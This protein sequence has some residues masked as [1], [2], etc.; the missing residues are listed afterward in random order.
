MSAHPLL[1]LGLRA[2]WAQAE[3][4]P[5]SPAPPAGAVVDPAPAPDRSRLPVVPP[6]RLRPPLEPVVMTLQNDVQAWIL[7][8][9]GLHRARVS[10]RF[11]D[12]ISG[13]CPRAPA[14]CAALGDQLGAGAG[15]LDAEAVAQ[16]LDGIDA[17]LRT[18]MG[19]DAGWVELDAPLQHLD[20]GLDRL[21]DVLIDPSLSR[22]ELRR[23]R[24]ETHQ[25]L[26]SHWPSDP[27]ATLSEAERHLWLPP[28]HPW[29]HRASPGAVRRVRAGDLR[30]AQA[31]RAARSPLTVFVVGDVDPETLRPH[32]ALL[33]NELGPGAAGP[34]PG[35]PPPAHAGQR[36]IGVDMPGRSQAALGLSLAAPDSASPEAAAALLLSRVVMD[37]FQSRINLLLREERGWTYGVAGRWEAAPGAARFQVQVELPLDKVVPAVVDI[38]SEL[39]RAAATPPSQAE[40]AREQAGVAREHNRALI[41][42]DSASAALVSAWR[43]GGAAALRAR[44]DAVMAV[45]PADVQALA[46]RALGPEAARR[47]VVVGDRAAL[48]PALA[49]AGFDVRWIS[50]QDAVLGRFPTD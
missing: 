20:L 41:D 10:V 32:L 6:P 42:E 35:P 8:T 26:T 25:A 2:A 30:A 23:W 22:R 40:L 45:Q 38:E 39:A 15:A 34:Q 29:G 3:A 31:E 12:G 43:W 46:A 47:W 7:P 19:R 24:R 11:A 44:A 18:A 28:D 17:E 36:W 4:E 50:P 37:G 13:L 5:P 14:R 21:R 49:A 16:A 27:W 48:G 1:L 33:I 9:P